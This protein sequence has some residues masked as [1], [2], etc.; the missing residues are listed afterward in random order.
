MRR[1]FFKGISFIDFSE[2]NI[3]KI[4]NRNGLFVFPAATALVNIYKNKKY[5]N[6]LKKADLVFFDS[7]FLVIL[8]KIFKNLNIN[9][10]SG[11]KFLKFLF[12]K[13]K[14]QKPKI[15][16]VD[17]N[18]NFSLNNFKYLMRLGI[19]KNNIKNY[20]C[21]IYKSRHIEDKHLLK[22]IKKFKPSIIVINIG[23]GTQEVLGFYLK[24]KLNHKCKIV[25]TG[26]AISFFTK[27]Q[28]PI[29]DF[30]DKYYLGW[31]V[32]FLFNPFSLFI[33]Y[34]RVFKLITMV[35]FSAVRIYD[36]K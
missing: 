28:A 2:N 21:P 7:G 14:Q 15:F 22:Q 19:K 13:I 17:P 12:K 26:A 4:L 29:N 25:C 10:F 9:K 32:R 24:K 30:I 27:D 8:F 20:V 3:N 16:L 5:Y 18:K 11:Y 36:Y 6:S 23:G 31:F 34:L 35:L 1:I 33:K